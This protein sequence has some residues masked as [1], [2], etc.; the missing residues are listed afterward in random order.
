MSYIFYNADPISIDLLIPELN[1][2]NRITATS[3]TPKYDAIHLYALIFNPWLEIAILR[4]PTKDIYT[5]EVEEQMISLHLP[6]I[7]YSY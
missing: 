7:I 1:K 4:L 6:D 2:D 5:T 3:S